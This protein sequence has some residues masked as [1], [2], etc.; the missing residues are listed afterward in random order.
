M[1]ANRSPAATA[2]WLLSV[3]LFVSFTSTWIWHSSPRQ[4]S[5]ANAQL[6]DLLH[7][8]WKDQNS[9]HQEGTA[10]CYTGN[11]APLSATNEHPLELVNIYDSLRQYAI[12]NTVTIIPVNERMLHFAQNMLCSLRKI[13]FD[14]AQL[15]FWTL[16]DSVGAT[17]EAQG[18][19][20]FHDPELF[21]ASNFEGISYVSPEFKHMML[22]RPKF[23]HSFLSTGL[24]LLFLD[25]DIIFYDDPLKILDRNVD[26]AI[27]SDGREFFGPLG[28]KGDPWKDPSAAGEYFPP[29]CAGTFWMKST[30]HTIKL[31]QIMMDV[32]EGD[33]SVA[34]LHD[35]GLTDDQRGFDV[36]LNDGRAALVEPL[37]D[38]ITKEMITTTLGERNNE[39]SAK[40]KVRILDQAWVA[41]GHLFRNQHEDYRERLEKLEGKG[42]QKLAIHLNWN[43]AVIGKVEGAKEMGIWQLE[44]DGTCK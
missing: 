7:R 37:P 6:S 20:T 10:T 23:F 22:E 34:Y 13:D 11:D 25:T 21:G 16:D 27:G 40:L 4:P 36:L 24:D 41:S 2:C 12:N 31:F 19:N 28:S 15:V 32:F 18:L 1:L 33:P 35:K 42:L 8:P 30:K 39:D 26:L 29:V 9:P 43:I 44:D 5:L 17:L 3:F 14:P 38:G